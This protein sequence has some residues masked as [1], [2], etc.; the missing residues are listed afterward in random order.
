MQGKRCI[1][2]TVVF[3]MNRATIAM[4][5]AAKGRTEAR[6]AK[7]MRGERTVVCP[8]CGQKLEPSSTTLRF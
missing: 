3:A 6:V 7:G 2:L 4:S 5:K 1:A 8:L